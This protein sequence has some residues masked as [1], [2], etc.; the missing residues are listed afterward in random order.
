MD[1]TSGGEGDFLSLQPHEIV[2]KASMNLKLEHAF[3]KLGERF[4]TLAVKKKLIC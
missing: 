4:C 1:P 2:F 3:Y